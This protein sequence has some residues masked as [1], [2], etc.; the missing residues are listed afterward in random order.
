MNPQ[1]LI[2]S[3]VQ[4]ETFSRGTRIRRCLVRYRERYKTTKTIQVAICGTVL[5]ALI[6]C[7][8]MG[9]GWSPTTLAVENSA[10]SDQHQPASIPITVT[11][12]A[13]ER[14][15]HPGPNSSAAASE[16]S[17]TPDDESKTI[18]IPPARLVGRWQDSFFGKRTLILNADGSARMIL[19][20]DFAGQ[21]LYG[22]S[23]EFDM[24]WSIDGAKV[25]IEL[26]EGRPAKSAQAAMKTWGNRYEYLLD[27]VEDHQI[28]MR[29]SD[30]MMNHVLRR[31]PAENAAVTP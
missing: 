17:V 28:E 8:L 29:S 12:L 15:T 10:T 30:G 24:T 11:P 4:H 21:L 14:S 25:T 5:L 27:C 9:C 16:D 6:S 1:R 3:A 7:G 23:L 22:R 18:D 13:A 31:I 20:L 2:R 19:D 26:L